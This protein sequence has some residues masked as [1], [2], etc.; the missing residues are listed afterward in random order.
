MIPSL[1]S[2]LCLYPAYGSIAESFS[3]ILQEPAHNIRCPDDPSILFLHPHYSSNSHVPLYL[4]PP[5]GRW[6]SP[7]DNPCL[8]SRY[9]SL[10][11][12][13]FHRWNGRIFAHD[14]FRYTYRVRAV[15]F[16]SCHSSFLVTGRRQRLHPNKASLPFRRMYLHSARW[17]W[18][19]P[20]GDGWKSLPECGSS[21]NL[22][23]AIRWWRESLSVPEV[24]SVSGDF[25][26]PDN[27]HRGCVPDNVRLPKGSV[28]VRVPQPTSFH[29]VAQIHS[30][31]LVRDYPADRI[32]HENRF[33][34]VVWQSYAPERSKLSA[35][36]PV[37]VPQKR[38]RKIRDAGRRMPSLYQNRPFHREF[39]QLPSSHSAWELISPVHRDGA[40]T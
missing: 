12:R 16:R 30:H 2:F 24:L 35:Y 11:K 13:S 10:D 8:Y 5:V 26:V 23:A 29:A 14:A 1:L 36:I 15:S 9:P 3:R 6:S 20:A 4:S 22:P 39:R 25:H 31:S 34:P 32:R 7:L 27:V 33:P 21:R 38:N 18:A 37:P 28:N 40:R 17:L 19:G